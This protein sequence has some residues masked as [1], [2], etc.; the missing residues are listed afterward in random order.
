MS[1]DNMADML[2]S[3]RKIGGEPSRIEATVRT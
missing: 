2:A 3:I 1:M